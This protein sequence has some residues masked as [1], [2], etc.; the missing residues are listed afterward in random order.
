MQE[1]SSSVYFII[2]IPF[3]LLNSVQSDCHFLIKLGIAILRGA[4]LFS[5]LAELAL[6]LIE[7]SVASP[8]QPF[9]LQVIVGAHVLVH[10]VED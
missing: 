10:Y 2:V 7:I 3:H 8:I 9:K 5:G 4:C 6:K 1:V